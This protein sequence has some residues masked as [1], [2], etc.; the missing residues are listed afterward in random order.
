MSNLRDYY[1]GKSV[2]I[3]GGTGFMGKVLVQRLLTCFP[4]IDRI[5]VHIRPSHKHGSAQNR[6]AAILRTAAFETVS[7]ADKNQHVKIIAM[8]GDILQPNL[9]LSSE[10]TEILIE[11]V[12]VIFHTAATVKFDEALK[13][14]VDVNVSGTRKLLMLCRQMKRLEAFIHVSTAY[15]NCNRMDISEEVYP[16]PVPCDKLIEALEWMNEASVKAITAQLIPPWPNTYTYAKAL[17]ESAIVS[18]WEESPTFHVGIVRPSIVGAA[19]EHP[20]P[21]YIDNYNGPSGLLAAIGKGALRTMLGDRNAIADIVPVDYAVDVLIATPWHLESTKASKPWVYNFTSGGINPMTWGYVQDSTLV[22]F[23]K[24]PVDNVYRIP[25]AR[26]TQNWLAFH[27]WR[28]IDHMLPAYLIDTVLRIQGKKP[29]AVAGYAK[30]HRAL[31]SLDYFTQNSW[32][33]RNDNVKLLWES[34]SIE[35][36]KVLSFDLSQLSWQ[37][38][39]EK[40]C[41]GIKVFLLR[42]SLDNL[43][44]ARKAVARQT[45]KTRVVLCVLFLLLT[46]VLCKSFR[47]VRRSW[48]VAFSTVIRLML[49]LS[50]ILKQS[51]ILP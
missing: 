47:L 23:A 50:R 5:Y 2:F 8:S 38:Y 9:G 12:S 39:M 44:Q 37:D 15:A 4:E 14:A 16:S 13:T 25:S 20:H 45:K 17:A 28:T 21:G 18:A 48:L 1:R 26:F 11:K 7:K 49:L 19:V 40:F 46:T 35:D 30:L 43:P 27:L 34:L 31:R 3:T 24:N 10:D 41:L 51:S 22:N 29:T 42:E 32:N 33:F 6:L 36:Q